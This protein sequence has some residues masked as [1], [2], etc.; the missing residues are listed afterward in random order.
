MACG[1]RAQYEAEVAALGLAAAR[2][3]AAGSAEEAAARW[4][5]AQRN[6]LKQRFRAFTPVDDLARLQAWTEARYGNPLG[7]SA[8][9]L[10]AQGKSWRR[11][12]DGAARPGQ[13]RGG[14]AT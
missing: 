11:I 8:D 14:A 2:M 4:I 13:Y 5:V 6:A 3:L 1:L 10:H 9:Q 7:P 12:I